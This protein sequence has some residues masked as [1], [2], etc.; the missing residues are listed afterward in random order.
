MDTLPCQD[1]LH[2]TCLHDKVG[3]QGTQYNTVRV[4]YEKPTANIILNGE[5]VA[6]N[7][8]EGGQDRAGRTILP[9]LL[10][11]VLGAGAPRHKE[12]SKVQ[13]EIRTSSNCYQQRK[14]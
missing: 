10:G 8:T 6:V 4:I 13:T 1:R 7:P 11:R 14:F 12:A 3:L 5:K 9:A 2:P